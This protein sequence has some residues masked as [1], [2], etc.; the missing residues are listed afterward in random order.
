MVWRTGAGS[1]RAGGDLCGGEEGGVCGGTFE[2]GDE[3]GEGEGKGAGGGGG[4][5]SW[6]WTV[7]VE[8]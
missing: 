8:Y 1:G 2:Y 7:E 6:G 3:G 5:L 4:A